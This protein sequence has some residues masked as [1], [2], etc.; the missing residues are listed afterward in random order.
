MTEAL[1]RL[2]GFH[3]SNPH[4]MESQSLHGHRV[5][6]GEVA[7]RTKPET[8]VSCSLSSAGLGGAGGGHG[9]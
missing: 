6:Q 5:S 9:G 8:S 7:C 3:V 4:E 1:P 2:S